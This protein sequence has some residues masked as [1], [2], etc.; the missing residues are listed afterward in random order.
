ML[1]GRSRRS[2][3]AR[4]GLSPQSPHPAHVTSGQAEAGTG[5]RDVPSN[6]AMFW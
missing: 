3:R 4:C 6:L 1:A 2:M 5:I